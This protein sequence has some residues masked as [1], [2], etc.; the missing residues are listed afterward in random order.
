MWL[1]LPG[2][3]YYIGAD[4]NLLT[5]GGLFKNQDLLAKAGGNGTS[6]IEC[7]FF[8]P[9]G[10]IE[11]LTGTLVLRGNGSSTNGIFNVAPG[12]TLDLPSGENPTYNGT[13][14]GT[15]VG[16]VGRNSGR[17]NPGTGI[18]FNFPNGVFCGGGLFRSYIR[19][20]GLRIT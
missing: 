8:N 20:N 14:T 16:R 6:V 5:G 13:Y 11:V 17:L 10:V 7:T 18:V 3:S 19:N 2:S 9:D 4:G 15:G 1:N 12:A